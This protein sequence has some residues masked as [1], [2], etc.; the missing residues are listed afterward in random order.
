MPKQ[1]PH[2]DPQPNPA[3]I[4]QLGF[5]YAPPLILETALKLG[6][7]DILDDGPKTL[8]EVTAATGAST[9]GVRTLLN[10]LV[11]ME[12]LTRRGEEYA[13][14]PESATFLVSSKPSFQ[15]GLLR[16]TGTH[17]RQ[18][19]QLTEAV[20]D[21]RPSAAVNR[22]QGG[23]EFFSGFVEDL[24]ALNYPAAQALARALDAEPGGLT[25]PVL[26]LAAGSGVWG[27][28]LA[29]QSPQ[30]RVTAVDWPT[31]TPVTRRVAGRFGVGDRV[32]CVNGDLMEVDFGTGFQVA[33]LGHILHS[34]GEERSRSL[35]RKVYQALAPGGTVVIA[36]ML[37]NDDRTG[38]PHALIFAVNMLVHTEHG[39]TFT[40]AE[41]GGWLEEAG[42]TKVHTLETPSPSPLVLA[43]KPG[44]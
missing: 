14:T 44:R 29:Q 43:V 33:V 26:D 40:L 7:F 31:V 30:A 19:L 1:P 20:R 15:G 8:A 34:E 13:L 6:V 32:E 10:A 23:A 35:L 18:W 17:V 38:P 37:P 42:F 41:I 27:I 3:R 16:H 2:A 5:A 12:F 24:F 4:L 9:R 22:E 25:G 36:E 21:G 28:A 39:D 11:G